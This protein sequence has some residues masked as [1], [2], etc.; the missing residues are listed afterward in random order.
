VDG[1]QLIASL[2]QSLV[3][4]AWPIAF[5]VAV[6]LFRERIR[7]LLPLLRLKYKDFDVSF[8][9]EKAEEEQ[10][11]LPPP[12]DQTPPTP[13]EVDRFREVARHS[14]R[15]AVLEIR[16]QIE[17][18][19]RLLAQTIGVRDL[20]FNRDGKAPLHILIRMLR[21]NNII[22]QPTSAILDDLRAIGNAAAHGSGEPITV[23]DALRFRSLAD[24]VI[25]QLSIATEAAKSRIPNNV[26]PSGGG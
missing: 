24:N 19:V 25:Q 23:D 17:E 16:A 7:L 2:F 15:A 21:K 14:P 4:L 18:A 8:R 10:A 9:L 12:T 20:P 3:S 22:D 11:K 26:I 1:Y 13:E 5:V 6:W